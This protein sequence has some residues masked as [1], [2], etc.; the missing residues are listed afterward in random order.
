M[1]W[2]A[3]PQ[4]P[5]PLAFRA[6]TLERRAHEIVIDLMAVARVSVRV[7]VYRDGVRLG[8]ATA[9]FERG[10]ESIPVHVGPKSLRRLRPGQHVTVTIEYGPPEPLRAHTTLRVPP[11]GQEPPAEAPPLI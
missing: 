10:T 4:P 2:P 7:S 6:A 11:P 8:R 9:A 1:L 5:P 3:P